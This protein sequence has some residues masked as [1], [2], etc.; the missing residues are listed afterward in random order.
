M[1]RL[2]LPLL[3]LVV[4]GAPIWLVMNADY[5][6]AYEQETTRWLE[7]FIPPAQPEQPAAPISVYSQASH[8]NPASELSRS[9]PN[10]SPVVEN[11]PN[12]VPGAAQAP[13]ATPPA[14]ISG[15]GISKIAT[16]QGMQPNLGGAPIVSDEVFSSMSGQ[17][18]VFP[19]TAFAPDLT[20]QPMEFVPTINLGTIFRFDIDANWIKNRWDRV[21]AT[22]LDNGLQGMRVAL[23]TGTNR[24]DLHGSLTYF[25]DANQECQRISFR[26][27]TG[28][29]SK[30]IAMLS[31]N[32]SFIQQPTRFAGFY[33]A[34]KKSKPTGGILMKHP[35][36]ISA[37]NQA[38]QVAMVLEIN[39]PDGKYRLSDHFTSMISVA[40]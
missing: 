19:G 8:R 12:F 29:H 14:V 7:A 3:L 18:L 23:V 5:P 11:L 27:W 28:D 36:V 9:V 24:D 2:I 38:Q 22:P 1:T 34:G 31:K 13:V 20:A 10:A 6:R 15:S 21:S 37:K 35:P 26:G 40:Q 33:L 4:I 16:G 25:F 30:L 17:T 39:R 32:F